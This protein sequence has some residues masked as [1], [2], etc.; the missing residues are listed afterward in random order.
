VLVWDEAG[1]ILMVRR[2]GGDLWTIPPGGLEK[3]GT[4]TERGDRAC[5]Q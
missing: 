2:P 5:A 4:I 1:R 3:H